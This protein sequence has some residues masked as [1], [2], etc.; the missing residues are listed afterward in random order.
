MNSIQFKDREGHNVLINIDKIYY[1]HEGHQA[2]TGSEYNPDVTII[3]FSNTQVV[4]NEKYNTVLTHI[5]S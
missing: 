3:G 5:P 4:V 1:I 2:K